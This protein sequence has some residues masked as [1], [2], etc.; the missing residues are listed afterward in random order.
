MLGAQ[1]TY[2]FIGT[3]VRWVGLRGPQN[4]IARVYLDGSFH[5]QVD[6]YA[7]MELETVVFT[8]MNLTP[9]RHT[10]TIEVTGDKN[11]ASTG[12]SVVV[13]GLDVRSR[14][15]DQD[16]ALTHTADWRGPFVKGPL[17]GTLG[18]QHRLA[19]RSTPTRG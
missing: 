4:G 3:E 19:S 9:G 12:T 15:E 1:A 18:N 11:A 16:H 10:M 14:F 7:S 17:G 2:S 13:D 6:T 8:A 5:A